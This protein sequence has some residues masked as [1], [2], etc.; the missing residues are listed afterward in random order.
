MLMKR[1]SPLSVSREIPGIRCSASAVLISGSLTISS[2]GCTSMMLGACCFSSIADA[3][4]I[5][6]LGTGAAAVFSA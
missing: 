1:P 3:R 6:G 4:S 5:D 2:S